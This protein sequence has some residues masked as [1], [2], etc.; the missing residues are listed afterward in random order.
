MVIGG[1]IGG[2]GR[3][4]FALV[5]F[6]FWTIVAQIIPIIW[7]R[8]LFSVVGVVVILAILRALMGAKIVIDKLTQTVTISRPSFFLVSR[9]RVIP[10]SDVRSVVIDYKTLTSGGGDTVATW[11]DAWKVSL[12]ISGKRF[13]I[14][15]RTKKADMFYLASGISEFIGRELVDNSAKPEFTFEGLFGKVKGFF[16][17]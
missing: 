4:A 6:T 17:K 2:G 11:Q 5:F 14:D 9:Q 10:F 3:L 13:K 16:R 8:A 12:D 1:P 7:V 15:H